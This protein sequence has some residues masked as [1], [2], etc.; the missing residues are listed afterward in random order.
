VVSTSR[1]PGLGPNTSRGKRVWV[2]AGALLVAVGLIEVRIVPPVVTVRWQPNLSAGNRAALER[3]FDL[4]AGQSTDATTWRYELGDRSRD[5][6]G[7]II[8]NPAVEDTGFIDRETLTTARPT[9]RVALRP[10]SRWLPFPFSTD[11]RFPDLRALLQPQSGIL[12]LAGGVLLLAA[13]RAADRVRRRVAASTLLIV[14]AMGLALPISPTFVTMG[15]ATFVT[16]DAERFSD[17]AGVSRVRFEA[18]LSYAVLGRLYHAM[19]AGAD[20][21]ERAQAILARAAT[22][23]FVVC[24][25]IVGRLE[26]WSAVSVRYLGLS[27]LA[28]ASL[29]YFGWREFGYLSLNVALFPLLLRGLRGGAGYLEAGSLLTGLG[30]ALHGFG[31]IALAGAMS[32]ALAARAT[33]DVRIRRMLLVAVWGAAAHIAWVAIYV[34]VFALPVDPGHA[35]GI[36]W[37]AWL[38]NTVGQGRVN[39]ALLSRLGIAELGIEF[40]LVGAPLVIVAATMWRRFGDEVR[41]AMAYTLP[42][43]VFLVCFWPIQGLNEETDLIVAAFPAL[44]ALAWTCAQDPT[45]AR[46]AAYLLASAHL[47]FWRT[48]LDARFGAQFV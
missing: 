25:L 26:R 17:Y 43:I 14:G 34:Q 18:H 22:V 20:A 12:L 6:I 16:R 32:M 33:R 42:S 37:R 1:Q 40:W 19:G 24:A 30:A 28:P 10:L 48:L 4:R 46:I 13:R 44:Y 41:A 23:W 29:L 7:A 2:V 11:E 35:E 3:R 5:N 9:P 8:R 39:V 38:G 27:L 15:D 47:P 36:P 45:R 21:P 31:L